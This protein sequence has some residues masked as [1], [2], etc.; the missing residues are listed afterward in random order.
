LI[1]DTL[2][3]IGLVGLPGAGKGECARIAK[4]AGAMVV[5]MGDIVRDYAKKM[6][7]DDSDESIGGMAHSQREKYGYGIW[8]N[9]T[10]EKILE[11]SAPTNSIS[12]ITIDGIRGDAEVQVFKDA[13]NQNFKTLAVKMPA[14]RRFELL[15]KRKRSDAPMTWEEFQLRDEREL[16]WGIQRA[17]DDA[18]YII[19]NTGTL[20]ELEESFKELLLFI[21]EQNKD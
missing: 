5:S 20:E 14:Q 21:Q 15:Q 3:I 9:R 13:F 8:A 7:L 6:E 11:I 1:G 18:D 17:I 16:K 2:L 10:V 4:E 19:L 12:I